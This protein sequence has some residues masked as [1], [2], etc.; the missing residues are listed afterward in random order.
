MLRLFVSP[1]LFSLDQ[2]QLSNLW[3][4]VHNAYAGPFV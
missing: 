4:T 2:D 1:G 3:E